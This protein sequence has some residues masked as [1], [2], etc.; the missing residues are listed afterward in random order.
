MSL[1][2]HLPEEV[3]N[4][5]GHYISYRRP[6]PDFHLEYKIF[7]QDWKNQTQ[8]KF[9]SGLKDNVTFDNDE[10]FFLNK[11]FFRH[12]IVKPFFDISYSIERGLVMRRNIR[13]RRQT[14]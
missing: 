6:P 3:Q 4:Q 10:I 5:V 1:F 2:D 13:I 8:G 9:W 14:I 7:C 12:Q 11:A